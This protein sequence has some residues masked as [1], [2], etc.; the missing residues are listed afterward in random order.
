MSS[1]CDDNVNIVM[2]YREPLLGWFVPGLPQLL[3]GWA[4]ATVGTGISTTGGA[5]TDGA[6]T[7]GVGATGVVP[8]AGD[9][10]VGV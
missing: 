2:G 4:G 10:F 6:L 7:E 9:V 8:P 1:R 3:P 5:E